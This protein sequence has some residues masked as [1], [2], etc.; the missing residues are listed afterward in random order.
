MEVAVSI[1][2]G[3]I[4][5][6][7][8]MA[9]AAEAGG[10]DRIHLDI[11]DGVFIPTFTVG[12]GAV[13]AVRRVTRLP[14]EVHL[15]TVDPERWIAVVTG[16][17][18]TR[19]IFHPEGTRDAPQMIRKI[20]EGGASVGL[21]LLLATPIEA[22]AP[23]FQQ[24]DQITI[25]STDPQ[26]GSLF[27]PLALDKA[28]ALAG[29]VAR[30]ELDGGVTPEIIAPAARAGVTAVVVGRAIFAQGTGRVAAAIGALR[31]PGGG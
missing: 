5:R 3:D 19:V 28:R 15:Q 30:I 21:A 23:W 24:V 9:V 1:T 17:R 7:A 18:A 25:M 20:Q 27:D 31:E 4:G 16:G 11:E 2:S 8:E 14:L 22:A 10:A 13:P 12:P 26:P 6:L 29:R